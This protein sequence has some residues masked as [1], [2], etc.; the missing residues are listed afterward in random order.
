[1]ESEAEAKPDLPARQQALVQWE[2]GDQF[3]V[4][5]PAPK[6]NGEAQ[7]AAAG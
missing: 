4:K 7:Q 2:K 6:A 1:M 3:Q 5:A